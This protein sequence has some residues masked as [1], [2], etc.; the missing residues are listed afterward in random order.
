MDD[1]IEVRDQKER[2]AL[3]EAVPHPMQPLYVDENGTVRFKPNRLIDW[4]VTESG[5]ITLNDLAVLT[6]QHGWPAE[7]HEQL[8]QLIGYSVSGF[9]DLSYVR[10]K[11]LKKADKR[12]AKLLKKNKKSAGKKA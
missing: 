7:D 6:A 3:A 2:R 4:I 11:T 12:C 1:E 8:A 5:R 9:G 10:K